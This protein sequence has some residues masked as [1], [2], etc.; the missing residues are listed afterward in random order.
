MQI[1][2]IVTNDNL[3]SFYRS[4]GKA[5]SWSV[6]DIVRAEV[7]NVM[8]SGSVALRVTQENG[9]S[10][11][12]TAKSQVPLSAG[13]QVLLKVSGGEGEIRLQL[14][15]T[16][17]EGSLIN[18]QPPE[19]MPARLLKILTDFSGLRLSSGDIQLIKDAF[20]KIPERLRV[21][22]PEFKALAELMP[23]VEE[24]NAGLLKQSVEGS[25]VLLETKLKLIGRN[26]SGAED[27]SGPGFII[28]G[29]EEHAD[30]LRQVIND[31]EVLREFK[32][33]GKGESE[34]GA[35]LDKVIR[36]ALE[37][38]GKQLLSEHGKAAETGDGSFR[39]ETDQKAV[40]IK[41]GAL[42]KDSDIA[43]SL[44]AAGVKVSDVSGAVDRLLKN[45][46]FFQLSSKVNDVL[47]TFLP[48]TW[49]E[50]RDGEITFR[51]ENR[52]G[53]RTFSCDI[54][55]DLAPMGRLSVSVTLYDGSY[56]V[57]FYAEE[58]TTKLLIESGKNH[59]QQQF[60]DNGL[61]LR[62]VNISGKRN[63][64]AGDGKGLHI[65]V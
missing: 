20:E 48:L 23:Q 46:E 59:L 1:P 30:V 17:T 14:V 49:Q 25:G 11:I 3:Y 62:V 52:S 64:G 31:D 10:A 24:L 33:S 51:K 21:A 56:H 36:K 44:K 19:T 38:S 32:L 15:S 16:A 40:L 63:P 27:G 9:E 61:P 45:I 22:I 39:P 35:T 34:I 37:G 4:F 54:N 65:R 50:M 47:Y 60:A 42:L 2:L 41:L 26:M 57:T 58:D 12:I 5:L 43:S 18:N 28:E 8:S 6:G 29:S 13:S 55:L 7:I 53:E